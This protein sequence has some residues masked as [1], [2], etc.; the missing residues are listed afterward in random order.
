MQ[1]QIYLNKE[2]Q[3]DNVFNDVSLVDTQSIAQ[4]EALKKVSKAVISNGKLVNFCSPTYSL[5]QNKDFF[6]KMEH[7]LIEEGINYKVRSFNY[8]DARFCVDYILDDDSKVITVNDQKNKGIDDT[9]VPMIRLVNSYDGSAKTAGYLGFFRKVCNNGLHMATTQLEF[10]VK[11][12]KNSMALFIP[13]IEDLV[14]R[15]LDNEVY[16]IK[17]KIEKMKTHFIGEKQIYEWIE[18]LSKE[19]KVFKFEKSD[20]NP[21]P[22]LNATIIHDIVVRDANATGVEPNAWLVYSAFNEL[23]HGK[24]NKR[25]TDQK[26]LDTR[27]FNNVSNLVGAY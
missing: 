4:F 26:E 25:F 6:G 18:Q 9:I 23:I 22:S 7:E 5:L 20:E 14:K 19:E 12:T 11:H 15:F 8:D 16:S 13:N 27:V 1:N 21:E 3:K 10:R 2:V 24:L 17:N